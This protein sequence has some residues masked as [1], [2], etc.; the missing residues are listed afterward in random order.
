MKPAL[1]EIKIGEPGGDVMLLI[2]QVRKG[3]LKINSLFGKRI[4]VGN[5]RVQDIGFFLLHTVVKMFPEQPDVVVFG[6]V[7]MQLQRLAEELKIVSGFT[8]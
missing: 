7:N 3:K 8:G 2:Q 4:A 6:R 1:V 5:I